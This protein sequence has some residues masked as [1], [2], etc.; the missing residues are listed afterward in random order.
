VAPIV[1]PP[2]QAQ[3]AVIKAEVYPYGLI[4]SGM[5]ALGLTTL[6]ERSAGLLARVGLHQAGTGRQ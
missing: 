1:Q 3:A 5:A 4:L 2:A 6:D